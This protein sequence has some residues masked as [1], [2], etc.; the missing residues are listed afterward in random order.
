[1]NPNT[2]LKRRRLGLPTLEELDMMAIDEMVELQE[3]LA[4]QIAA[5]YRIVNGNF[6]KETK[7]MARNLLEVKNSEYW[8]VDR[9]IDEKISETS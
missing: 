9:E 6:S 7:K 5:L 8:N 2:L 3:I 1:M 4:R